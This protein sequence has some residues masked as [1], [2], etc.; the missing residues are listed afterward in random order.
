MSLSTVLIIA[1]GLAA[2]LDWWAVWS[3]QPAVEALAK[4]AVMALLI[5]AVLTSGP[6][7]AAWLVAIALLCSLVGDVALLPAVDKFI[8]G[9][10]AFLLGHLA[11][12]GAFIIGAEDPSPILL[13]VGGALAAAAFG[14]WGRHIVRQA[15]RHNAALA[16]PVAV[17]IG[18]LSTMLALGLFT[19]ALL[20]ALGAG[21]FAASDVVLGWNRFVSPLRHGRLATHVPYQLGQGLIAL[22]AIGL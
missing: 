10:G 17:Y 1:A 5:A 11:Y 2:L 16:L 14:L 22:W 15:E 4:P 20:A 9:L 18:V 3:P 6:P 7:L 21:L 8:M 19:S 12:A 13:L